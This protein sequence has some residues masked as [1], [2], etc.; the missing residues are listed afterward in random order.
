MTYDV[1][2]TGT[3]KGAHVAKAGDLVLAAKSLRS[4]GAKTKVKL[5]LSSRLK[6]A[7]GKHAKLKLTVIAVDASGNK[8]TIARTIRVK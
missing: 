1:E 3:L 7:I 2:L 6:K 8:T 4:D 5:K